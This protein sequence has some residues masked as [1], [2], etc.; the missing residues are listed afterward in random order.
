MIQTNRITMD[1]TQ[2]PF[3]DVTKLAENFARELT[4]ILLNEIH[5]LIPEA[6]AEIMRQRADTNIYTVGGTSREHADYRSRGHEDDGS[7]GISGDCPI[8]YRSDSSTQYDGESSRQVDR[9]CSGVNGADTE[10]I[11]GRTTPNS[12]VTAEEL[13]LSRIRGCLEKL[14]ATATITVDTRWLFASRGIMWKGYG[15]QIETIESIGDYLERQ[16]VRAAEYETQLNDDANN[17]GALEHH[18]RFE[19]IT[20]EPT[21]SGTRESV[22]RFRPIDRHVPFLAELKAT[23]P[24]NVD[25]GATFFFRS[26]HDGNRSFSRAKRD[27]SAAG[28]QKE[29]QTRESETKEMSTTVAN[30]TSPSRD[31]DGD[32]NESILSEHTQRRVLRPCRTKVQSCWKKVKRNMLVG[33][34]VRGGL[35][36]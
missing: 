9:D 5:L 20:I 31:R 8:G 30:K 13:I 18:G 7:R 16:K 24:C 25:N 35:E 34:S 29:Q 23:V 28:R 4:S 21:L 17:R 3:I 22:P 6:V 19:S 15:D 32:G 10:P 36:A 33:K 12:E 14:N 27:G 11:T 1:P 2:P 26:R